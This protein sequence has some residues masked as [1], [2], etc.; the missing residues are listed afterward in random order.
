[1]TQSPIQGYVT[2]QDQVYNTPVSY[3]GG[4]SKGK[5]IPIQAGFRPRR[6]QEVEAPNF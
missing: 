5:A 1:M 2:C 3:L 4:K 6:F